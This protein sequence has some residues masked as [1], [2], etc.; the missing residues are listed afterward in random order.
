MVTHDGGGNRSALSF[1]CRLRAL[2]ILWAVIIVVEVIKIDVTG[3][4]VIVPIV[5]GEARATVIGPTEFETI[6]DGDESRSIQAIGKGAT[7]LVI[8]D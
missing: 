3:F 2:M 8:D 7:C 5:E 1:G 4:G 6:A